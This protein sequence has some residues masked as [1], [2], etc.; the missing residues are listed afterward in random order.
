MKCCFMINIIEK[1]SLL[2]EKN[3][4]FFYLEKGGN[5]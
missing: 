4:C 2:V 1:E 3:F 5:K